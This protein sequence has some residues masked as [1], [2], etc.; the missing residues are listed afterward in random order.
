MSTLLSKNKRRINFN[1]GDKIF[2]KKKRT[3]LTMESMETME[4]AAP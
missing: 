4:G 1:H 2:K 3:D